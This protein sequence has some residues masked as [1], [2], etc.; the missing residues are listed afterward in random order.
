MFGMNVSGL[1]QQFNNYLHVLKWKMVL[2]EENKAPS[3]TGEEVR[4][5][6]DSAERDVK[7]IVSTEE[8]KKEEPKFDFVHEFLEPTRET[9]LK[10]KTIITEPGSIFRHDLNP[11]AASTEAQLAR[12]I[13]LATIRSEGYTASDKSMKKLLDTASARKPDLNDIING[14]GVNKGV[15]DS[16]YKGRT[17]LG[18]I[19]GNRG[20]HVAESGAV[21]YSIGSSYG[22]PSYEK[23]AEKSSITLNIETKSG[24]K[25]S[26]NIDITDTYSEH[27]GNLFSN[28]GRRGIERDVQVSF[29]AD[30]SLSDDEK[31][32]LNRLIKQFNPLVYGFHEHL[33]VK[34]SELNDFVQTQDGIQSQFTNIQVDFSTLKGKHNLSV[35]KQGLQ[36][37]N[38]QKR[39]VDDFYLDQSLK[40]GSVG[41]NTEQYNHGEDLQIR[42]D[43]KNKSSHFWQRDMITDS[44]ANFN[45][46]S[47]P[48]LASLLG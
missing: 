26:V 30:K 43:F 48:V 18:F 4:K 15:K 23:R 10:A 16:I 21:T 37:M 5:M 46:S 38:V 45:H 19:N 12:R 27:V 33:A 47:R 25:L 9:L 3:I 2:P 34:K 14:M 31:G 17:E 7:A 8:I 6:A 13:T 24:N 35:S 20:M 36:P 28:G 39:K 32:A 29:N 41:A 1:N 42:S 22:T 40:K 44:Y 11:K